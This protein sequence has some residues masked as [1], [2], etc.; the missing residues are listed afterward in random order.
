MGHTRRLAERMNLAAMT[1][2]DELASTKYCLANPGQEYLVY[3]PVK[4]PLEVSLPAG[5]FDVEWFNPQTGA[6]TRGEPIR[7]TGDKTRLTPPWDGPAV[8]YLKRNQE[9]K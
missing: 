7:A 5:V 4:G 3:Q 9:S 2:R 8:V 6:S 1:P